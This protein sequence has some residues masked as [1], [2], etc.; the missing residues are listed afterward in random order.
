MNIYVELS[1]FSVIILLYWVISEMFTVLFRFTGLPEEKA[2]FQVTSLLTGCGFTTRESET[3][4]A[5]RNRRNLARITMLFGYVFNITI[6]SAI[7]NIF[8]SLKLRQIEHYLS[9]YLFP[10][11]PLALIFFLLRIPRFRSWID[12]QL[13]ALAGRVLKHESGNTLLIL[14]HLG[15]DSIVSVFLKTVPETLRGRTLAGINMKER[16]DLLIL[17]RKD[18]A[19]REQR[20]GPDTVLNDGDLLTVYGDPGAMC[21]LFDCRE[22][23][24]DQA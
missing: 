19:G 8:F 15:K 6:V 24:E 13:T 4:I 17:N 23:F 14:D 7:V 18:R 3:V 10:L 21:T 12:W 5:T 20:V 16:Q 22:T 2:R 9:V 11:L 1:L